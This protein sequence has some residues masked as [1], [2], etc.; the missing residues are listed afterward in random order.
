M[1]ILVSDDRITIREMEPTEKDFN[2]FLKWMTDPET[3]RFW[4]GMTVHFTYDQVVQQ[5]HEHLEEK[6]SQC[7]IELDG[8]PIGYCQFCELDAEGYDVPEE[9]W[10][11]FVQAD[12][13]V[14]GIDIFIGEVDCRDRGLGTRIM[15]LLCEALHKKH[16]ATALMIDPKTHNT[17][18]IRCYEKCGFQRLF[19]VP[20]REEQDGVLHDSL[21]MGMRKA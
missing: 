1:N 15:K 5:Y 9:E 10:D 4:D 11:R 19:T 2:Q 17:R 8:N 18:A 21:I 3:M 16:G 6:V 7:F 13:T 14:Y 12:D 20:Q